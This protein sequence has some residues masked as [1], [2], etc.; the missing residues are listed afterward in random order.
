MLCHM[1]F[2]TEL[3]QTNLG[4]SWLGDNFLYNFDKQ[5]EVFADAVQHDF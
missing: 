2:E 4:N 3:L 5:Q 1:A